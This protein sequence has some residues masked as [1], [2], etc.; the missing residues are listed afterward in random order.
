MRSMTNSPTSTK[1]SRRAGLNRWAYGFVR[2]AAVVLMSAAASAQSLDARISSVINSKQSLQSAT[3]G[4]HVR[5]AGTGDSLFGSGESK[6]LIP[7]SNMKLI[8]TGAALRVLGPDKFF[9]TRFGWDGDRI[10]IIGDG[11]PGLGDPAL[12]DSSEPA[13]TVDEMLDTLAAA[14]AKSGHTTASAIEIDDRVL[15]RQYVHPDWP[16]D[17]LNRWYCAE[18]SGINFHTNCLSFFFDASRSSGA[19]PGGSPDLR[20]QPSIDGIGRWLTVENKGKVVKDGRHTAWVARAAG[21]RPAN[22]YTVFG[23]V[24]MGGSAMV[25]VA[26]HEPGK[27]LGYLLAERLEKLGVKVERDPQGLANITLADGEAVYEDFE[28]AAVVRTS[29]T[30]V[31][32][33]ANTNSQNLYTEALIKR[34]GHEITREPG[35]W[36][37]GASVVRMLLAEDLGPSHATNT[38]IDDGS[39][40]SRGNRVAPETM[41]AWLGNLLRRPGIGEALLAS[42]PSPGTGTLRKRFKDTDLTNDVFAKTGT[43]NGVRGLSGF[44]ITPDRAHAVAFSVLI[45]DIEHGSQ[46]RDAL[47]LHEEVVVAID[48]WLADVAPARKKDAADALGG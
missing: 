18:V 8:T 33:R 19:S 12:L 26:V 7:A 43:I 42:M 47:N 9:E 3:I 20:L 2:T 17:Q 29:M 30:D 22:D 4:V 34:I 36:N 39:G 25:D 13:T 16:I 1:D 37:S 41:T 48:G 6:P 10:V 11:D 40:M 31:L 27:V 24:R 35:S 32:R 28:P 44:V 46:I 15:D 38:K 14:L 45:N 23:N 21:A 5:D